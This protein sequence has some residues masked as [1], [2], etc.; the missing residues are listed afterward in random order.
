MKSSRRCPL[1]SACAGV[2]LALACGTAFSGDGSPGAAWSGLDRSSCLE[3]GAG[4]ARVT[5]MISSDFVEGESR[6]R[7]SAI[8]AILMDRGEQR[9]SQH[10]GGTLVSPQWVVTARHCLVNVDVRRLIVRH[11]SLEN[12]KGGETRRGVAAHF[13][14]ASDAVAADGGAYQGS[15]GEDIALLHLDRPFPV[16]GTGVAHLAHLSDQQRNLVPGN[17]AWV[18]GWGSVRA[19]QEGEARDG[20]FEAQL[21]HASM[22]VAERS[23]CQSALDHARAAAGETAIAVEG[24]EFCA[25]G[26]G[27]DSCQGDSGGP[28]IVKDGFGWK[29]YGIVRWGTGCGM[30]DVPGVYTSVAQYRKWIDRVIATQE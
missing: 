19:Y 23:A 20:V 1:A 18:A 6:E 4:G 25:G 7:W 29:L 17:C 16:D 14:E 28:L 24:D 11:A 12:D 21:R 10:C 5:R 3:A 30:N 13:P 26:S 2:V 8:V 27:K 15:A 9:T 22:P